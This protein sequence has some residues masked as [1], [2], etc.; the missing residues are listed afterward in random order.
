MVPLYHVL[1]RMTGCLA[2]ALFALAAFVAPDRAARAA[3]GDDCAAS[4]A[5]APDYD[6]CVATCCKGLCG[7]YDE[8]CPTECQA[9][10]AKQ[11]PVSASNPNSSCSD[12]CILTIN[13][14][15]VNGLVPP[16]PGTCLKTGG[17]EKCTCKYFS[18][19]VKLTEGCYC[20]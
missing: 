10:A 16:G 17:C 9:G 7:E 8:T 2:I 11:C 6:A 4:C 13:Y 19:L 1:A 18:D 15:C 20:Y 3:F 5:S 14:T 12:A